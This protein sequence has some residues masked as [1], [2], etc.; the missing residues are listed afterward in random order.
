MRFRILGA[1]EVRGDSG[2]LK[3]GGRKQQGLLGL[4]LLRPNEVVS[5]EALIDGLW[6]EEP[7]ESAANALQVYVSGLRKVLGPET[8]LTRP[9]GYELRVDP[10]EVDAA[11]F[12]AGIGRGR[13]LVAAG[14]LAGGLEALTQALQLWRGRPLAGLGLGLAA[15]AEASRLDELRLAA[16]EDQIDAELALGRHGRVVPELEALAAE[17]PHRERLAGQLMLALYRGGRQVEAL[18]VYRA[19]RRYLT[20]ELGLEPS[21][22]LQEL[23]RRILGHDPALGR[24]RSDDVVQPVRSGRRQVVVLV[25]DLE[26]RGGAGALDPETE[27]HVLVPAVASAARVLESHGAQVERASWRLRAIFGLA[28][29]REDDARRAASAGLEL[30]RLR[31]AAP[32]GVALD[33]RI[34]LAAGEVVS[35][36]AGLA[37]STLREAEALARDAQPGEILLGERALRLLSGAE[38]RDAGRGRQRLESLDLEAEVIPRRSDLAFV[39]RRKE[40]TYLVGALDAVIEER[41][42]RQVVV[43]GAPGIGKSRLTSELVAQTGDRATSVSGRTRPHGAGPSLLPMAEIV[44]QLAGEDI[45]A[46]VRPLLRGD[47]HAA[48]VAERLSVGLGTAEGDASQEQTY[49]AVRRLLEAVARRRPLVVRLEDLHWADD[50]LLDLVDYLAE[51]VRDAPLLLVVTGRPELLERRPEWAR[52]DA[53]GTLII[54]LE[55]L[56]GRETDRM[57]AALSERESLDDAVRSRIAVAAEGNPLFIE[58]MVAMAGELGTTDDLLV[59]PSTHALMAAR[60][61]LLGADER[62]VVERAAVIGREFS[63]AGLTHLAIGAERA[64]LLLEALWRK[65]FVDTVGSGVFRFRHQLIADVAYKS[66]PKAARVELHERLAEALGADA[67]PETTGYHL[68]RAARYLEEFDRGSPAA[69]ALSEKARERL[70]LAGRRALARDDV[71]AAVSLLTRATTLPCGPDAEDLITLGESLRGHG[72]V[73]RSMKALQQAEELGASSGR[74]E[75]S[76]RATVLR[77]ELES[78]SSQGFSIDGGLAALASAM[79]V[80]ERAGCARGLAD[81]WWAVSSLQTLASDSERAAEALEHAIEWARRSDHH[82]LLT[83]AQV[84]LVAMAWFGPMAAPDAVSKCKAILAFPAVPPR[85]AAAAHRA[86]AGLFAIQGRFEEA[87]THLDHDRAIVLDVGLRIAVGVGLTQRA[88]VELLADD[89]EAAEASC[90]DGIAL[91]AETGEREYFVGIQ[92]LLADVLLRRGRPDEAL[93]LT[94]VAEEHGIADDVVEQAHWRSVRG[95]LLALRGEQV[96]AER[97]AQEAVALLSSTDVLNIRAHALLDLGEVLS[98]GADV[99]ELLRVLGEAEELFSRKGNLVCLERVEA[100]RHR[101]LQEPLSAKP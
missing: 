49:W 4:L 88:Y 24:E 35:G 20:D 15:E 21:P 14:E 91:L 96:E 76:A 75:V 92:V 58:Q 45:R 93:E 52:P 39:G 81:A 13:R 3:L 26:A 37:G 62:E 77:I 29:S 82:P 101:A 32:V 10:E 22:A 6:G 2:R 31:P 27:E 8:L 72:E 95:K 57:I 90:R 78:M 5:V 18:D 1:L 73:P 33:V 61:D 28:K 48:L 25:V 12:E 67:P 68:E 60:L 79:T 80:L 23:E 11:R 66:I 55:P 63:L 87:R 53:N 86:L 97:L 59:P 30:L 69:R 44:H 50:A 54:P 56:G 40:L 71:A 98:H 36:P 83:S 16:L 70:G 41:T 42:C 65:Q 34:G 38:I 46:G 100:L 64:Q 43:A 19:A 7:P 51:R 94:R 85:L 74:P 89:L 84:Q 47:R 17:H 9:P 99:A